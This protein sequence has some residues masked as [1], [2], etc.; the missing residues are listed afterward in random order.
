VSADEIFVF[1]LIGVSLAIVG[2]AAF[3]SRRQQSASA[4]AAPTDA[5]SAQA[6]SAEP[7]SRN[8]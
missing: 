5:D 8:S 4:D 6:G 3:R 1:A 2:F 7:G